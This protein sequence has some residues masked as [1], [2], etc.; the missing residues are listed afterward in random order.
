M[1]S[2]ML[3]HCSVSSSFSC[4]S[5]SCQQQVHF[6]MALWIPDFDVARILLCF[7]GYKSLQ[8]QQQPLCL[9]LQMV[10]L[11]MVI[12]WQPWQACSCPLRRPR[13]PLKEP[14]QV[15]F[16]DSV[17]ILKCHHKDSQL[18]CSACMFSVA[19]ATCAFPG[20]LVFHAWYCRVSHCVVLAVLAVL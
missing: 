8:K 11:V 9:E 7:T 14:A 1:S 10:V 19:T 20:R 4:D 18:D 3:H 6:R 12:P 16:H 17:D 5:H 2:K 13:Q 15:H